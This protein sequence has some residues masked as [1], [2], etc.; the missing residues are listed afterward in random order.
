VVVVLFALWKKGRRDIH[1]NSN[2]TQLNMENIRRGLEKYGFSFTFIEEEEDICVFCLN[3]DVDEMASVENRY[4]VAPHCGHQICNSCKRAQFPKMTTAAIRC[5]A[6]NCKQMIHENQLRPGNV[7][8]RER[9]EFKNQAEIRRSTIKTL[10]LNPEEFSSNPTLFNTLLDL[11]ESIIF[12]KITKGPTDRATERLT[13]EYAK[14]AK[15]T[16]AGSSALKENRRKEM[17]HKIEEERARNEKKKQKAIKKVMNQK[18]LRMNAKKEKNDEA[19][20]DKLRGI[21]DDKSRKRAYQNESDEDDLD[22]D[23]KKR[24]IEMSYGRSSCREFNLNDLRPMDPQPSSLA[25][26]R[27]K[28]RKENPEEF[29]RFQKIA[30]GFRFD[31]VQQRTRELMTRV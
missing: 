4:F 14:L 11:R 2:S 21:E 25:T 9:E 8:V 18:R 6:P 7:A 23:Q 19:L 27:A 22:E 24:K 17:W 3:R 29:Q 12:S 1:N 5:A 31:L 28:S 20:G 16:A 15:V 10:V 26:A 13:E 30:G